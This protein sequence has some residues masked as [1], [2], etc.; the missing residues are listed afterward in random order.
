MQGQ[1]KLTLS[2]GHVQGL[3]T[4]HL[5]ITYSLHAGL[6]TGKT[7]Q[8]KVSHRDSAQGLSPERVLGHFTTHMWTRLLWRGKGKPRALH[9]RR[10]CG[11]SGQLGTTPP[12][13]TE[14]G[15]S[16][17]EAEVGLAGSAPNENWWEGRWPCLRGWDRDLKQ[18]CFPILLWAISSHFQSWK[19]EK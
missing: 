8:A 4:W 14:L 1:S 6:L 5:F 13:V 3:E 12:A 9:R 18:W 10:V 17:T 19:R 7:N 2:V 16:H 15:N 11:C